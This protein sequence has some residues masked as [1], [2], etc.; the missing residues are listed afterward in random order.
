VRD[1]TVGQLARRGRIGAEMATRVD[2]LRGVG[3]RGL[4]EEHG[5]EVRASRHSLDAARAA[6]YA[7][8][9]RCAAAALGAEVEDLGRDFL[10]VRRGC[11]STLVRR[12]LVMLDHPATL[13]LAGDKP[14]VH[15]LLAGIGLPVP[16]HEEFG[17]ADASRGLDFLGHVGGPC[18]VKPARATG[19]GDGVTGGIE[20]PGEV[21]RALARAARFGSELLIE[22]SAPGSE[23][24]LLFLDGELLD[25]VRRERPTVVGDGVRSVRALVRDENRRRLAAG[26]ADT[27]RRLRLDLDLELAVRHAGH[28]L[29]SVLGPGERLAVKSGV[30]DN[31]A[32][33]NETVHGFAP[34]V[35]EEAAAAVSTLRLRL[36]G[37]D[38]VTPDPT[39]SLTDSGGVILEV[40]STPGFHHHIAVREPER[41]SPVVTDVLRTLLAA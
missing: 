9:W 40:N 16:E 34:A 21:C 31:A 29:D 13:E 35:V 27:A 22:S 33:D 30:S 37:V 36:A 24:R 38:V 3:I 10:V 8:A 17:T 7:T 18:V 14:L 20:R 4:A 12:H 26:P 41:A 28:R 15:R 32:G 6:Q 39:K 23:Y 2:M 1:A 5:R 11:V 25:V 19:A